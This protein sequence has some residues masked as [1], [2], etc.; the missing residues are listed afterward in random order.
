MYDKDCSNSNATVSRN[1]NILRS[2]LMPLHLNV[3]SSQH[4]Q[5]YIRYKTFEGW[6]IIKC[7]SILWDDLTPPSGL[8]LHIL[9]QVSET[10]I[11]PDP[12]GTESG[13]FG[14]MSFLYWWHST[15]LYVCKYDL[16]LLSQPKKHY[17]TMF[18]QHTYTHSINY[19]KHLVIWC[20]KTNS[21][22]SV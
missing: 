6:D 17:A 14:F 13:T 10:D 15:I 7:H 1:I 2:S 3:W 12:A 8:F 16:S 5:N 22:S 9:R 4:R 21:C 18:W 20:L 19:C 11:V